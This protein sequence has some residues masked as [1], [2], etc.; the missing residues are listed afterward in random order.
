V[1]SVKGQ[2]LIE[3]QT[4]NRSVWCNKEQ[5]EDQ[6]F[7]KEGVELGTKVKLSKEQSIVVPPLGQ[8]CNFKYSTLKQKL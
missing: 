5:L 3:E 7:P 1:Q 2:V 6:Q 8:A 4:L